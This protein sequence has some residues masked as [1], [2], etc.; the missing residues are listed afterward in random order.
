MLCQN[1]LGAKP[2]GRL[3]CPKA[4]V[5]EHLK[6]TH[7]DPLRNLLMEN[8]KLVRP[9]KPTVSF[10]MKEIELQEIQDVIMKARGGSAP[11][12]DAIPY[13]VYKKCLKLVRWLWKDNESRMET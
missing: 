3:Q 10:N 4:D 11:G 2:S 5:E 13:K 8:E 1:S 12:P 9:E 7:S 6:I